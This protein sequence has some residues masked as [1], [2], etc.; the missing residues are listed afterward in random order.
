MLSYIA[1]HKKSSA[2]VF[3]VVVISTISVVTVLTRSS[4]KVGYPEVVTV[5]VDD[6]DETPL[7]DYVWRGGPDDPKFIELPT[8]S[9]GG[10]IQKVDVDQRQE[11]GVPSNVGLAGWFIKSSRPGEK[12]LSIIDGHVDGRSKPGIFKNL[13]DLKNGDQFTVEF[14]S[15]EKVEFKVTS[16]TK[17]SADDAPRVLFSQDPSVTSQLNLITCG[18]RYDRGERRYIDRIIVT[19][20]PINPEV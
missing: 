5:S 16:Q 20:V 17:I 4:E 1:N 9:A 14:G 12:G 7:D 11:V 3:L 15:G 13:E 6:P 2:A 10:F 8:I 18:G 19:S